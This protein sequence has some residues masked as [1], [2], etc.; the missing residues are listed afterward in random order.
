MLLPLKTLADFN[1]SESAATSATI[2]TSA[3]KLTVELYPQQAPLTVANFVSL[4]E[5]GF[6]DDLRFHRVEPGFVVQVGDPES[7]GVDDEM[8]LL[9]LG[10]GYP[11]Y[12]IAD[13]LDSQLS[14]DQAG[15]LSMANINVNG[16]YPNSGGSQFFITLAPATQLDGRHAIFGKV[17]DGLDVLDKI[18]VGDAIEKIQII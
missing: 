9:G 10:T 18:K 16:D 5:S 12:R 6:Y 7:R 4:A 17:I 1:A 8:Q 13:E 11:G 3:G 2:T 14:H 15:I